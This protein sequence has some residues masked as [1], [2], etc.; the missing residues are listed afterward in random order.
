MLTSSEKERWEC[1][2]QA[3]NARVDPAPRWIAVEERLPEAHRAVL[4]A[5]EGSDETEMAAWF[6]YQNSRG[7]TVH[8]WQQPTERVR[9][10][11]DACFDYEDLKVTHWM[12]LPALPPNPA[13]EAGGV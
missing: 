7:E 10:D 3:W 8:C 4:V 6:S 12:P 1:A 13:S 9:I 11:G 5:I 2:A